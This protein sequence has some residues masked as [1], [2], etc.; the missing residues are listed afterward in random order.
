MFQYAAGRALSVRLG[1]VLKLDLNDFGSYRLHQGYELSRIFNVATGAAAPDEIRAV[2]GWQKHR[3]IRRAFQGDWLAKIGVAHYL[4]EP[5]LAYWP[6]FERFQGHAYLDGY[7]QSE[8]YFGAIEHQLRA[9]F[10]FPTPLEGVNLALAEQIPNEMSVSL[11]IR[12]GD[13]VANPQT[14]A[15]HGTC[16]LDYY[17]RAVRFIVERFEGTRFYAFSDDMAWVR[18]NLGRPG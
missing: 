8:R 5:S 11:H 3:W 9:D 10:S 17:E 12:R 18:E 6:M 2:L 16:G 14:A 13:Y 1:Q 15:R 7:W 4:R